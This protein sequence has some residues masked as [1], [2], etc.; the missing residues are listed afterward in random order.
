MTTQNTLI[1]RTTFL[2]LTQAASPHYY[3]ASTGLNADG[4]DHLTF[5]LQ[6]VSGNVNNFVTATIHADDG[7]TGTFPWDESLGMWNWMTGAY[8]TASWIANNSTVYARLQATNHNARLW[9][10][11]LVIVDGA[12]AAN[13]GIIEIR[14]IKV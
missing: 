4:Y 8:G 7:T 13:S 12:A 10:V 9:R 6:L 11:R 3:P 2:N 14:G 1:Y 5:R